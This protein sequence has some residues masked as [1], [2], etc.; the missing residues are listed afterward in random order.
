MIRTIKLYEPEH[1]KF[2]DGTV[3]DRDTVAVEPF[4]KT[5][6]FGMERTVWAEVGDDS[7]LYVL[8]CGMLW[9]FTGNLL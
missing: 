4:A 7:M 8:F 6:D 5:C 3:L 2:A 9:P 1:F